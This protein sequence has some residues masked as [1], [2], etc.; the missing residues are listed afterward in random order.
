M[1]IPMDVLPRRSAIEARIDAL[2]EGDRQTAVRSEERFGS[3]SF[4][5]K[6][7]PK[8]AS[9]EIA[10]SREFGL[11]GSVQ[12]EVGR[13]ARNRRHP[14][15]RLPGGCEIRLRQALDWRVGRL[16]PCIFN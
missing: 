5:I 3:F 8:Y 7:V 1:T 6:G 10:T 14:V 13:V 12:P 2:H 4:G 11:E 15:G 9:R 16:L